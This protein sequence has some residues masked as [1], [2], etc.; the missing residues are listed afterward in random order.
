MRFFSHGELSYNFIHAQLLI[1]HLN[2]F[3]KRGTQKYANQSTRCEPYNILH[4]HIFALRLV[5][6]AFKFLQ[7][8]ISIARP[9]FETCTPC[10]RKLCQAQSSA[11]SEN[12]GSPCKVF[13]ETVFVA[14][15]EHSP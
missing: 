5:L 4:V 2:P 6:K 7:W 9:S 3:F 8:I 10:I 11:T 15:E 13:H 12:R 14:S 1:A